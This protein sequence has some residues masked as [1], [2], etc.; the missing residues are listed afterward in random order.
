MKPEEGRQKLLK[1][2]GSQ[3]VF[4]K[5][6]DKYFSK[7]KDNM[8][9]A[10]LE[11]CN[12][13]NKGIAKGSVPPLPKYKDKFVFFRKIGSDIRATLVKQQ[14]SHFIEIY[15]DNYKSY[16]DLRLELGYKKSSYYMS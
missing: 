9:L 1:L 12:D 10:L 5:D 4:S 14:N 15:L 7:L 6:F 11:W 8:Q 16:D 13:C 3:L 2:F